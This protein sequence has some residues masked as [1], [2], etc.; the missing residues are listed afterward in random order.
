LGVRN[1][2]VM[3]DTGNVHGYN[4]SNTA[5]MMTSNYLRDA[6]AFN[7]QN[8]AKTDVN[9]DLTALARYEHNKAA[10]YEGGYAR[11]TRSPSLY[12]RYAWST[13]TMASNMNNWTGDGNGYVGKINLKPE[14]A[15]TVSISGDWHDQARKAWGT[16]ITPYYTYVQDYIDADRYFIPSANGFGMLQLANHDAQLYGFDIS[17]NV[18][19]WESDSL[20]RGVFKAVLGYVRGTNLDTGDNLYNIMPFNARLGFEHKLGGWRNS[21]DAQLVAPKRDVSI[22]RNELKTPG[23]A[24]INLATSYEWENITGT[25]GIDNLFDKLYYQPLGGADLSDTNKTRQYNVPGI[26]RSFIGG[27]TVKF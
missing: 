8:H 3:M 27:I 13:G 25:L 2:T 6:T 7:G 17:G 15:H 5:G 12:E 21:I 26:G 9:F 4:F 20:G 24:V 1:D 18:E 11:K 10:A 22:E 19:A 16:K 23:Y 14:V